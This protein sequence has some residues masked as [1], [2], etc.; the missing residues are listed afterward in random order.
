MKNSKRNNYVGSE[1]Y[2]VYTGTSLPAFI[3]L[4]AGITLPDPDYMIYR[5]NAD[6]FVFEYLLD[7]KG[8][9][10]QDEEEIEVRSGDAY[11]LQAGKNHY[12]YA[13]KEM[14]WTKIW[15]NVRGSLVRHLLSDYGLRQTVVIPQFGQGQYLQSMLSTIEE[16]PSECY[17]RLTIQLHEYIQALSS[18]YASHRK[19]HTF[20]FAMK[21]YIEQN[22]LRT[23]S[24]DDIAQSAHLSS[25]RAIHIFKEAFGLP[26]YQY[27][28]AQRL[29]LVQS[30]LLYTSLSIQEI[31]DRLGFS[32]YHHLSNSFKKAY[33][34]SPVKFRNDSR[35]YNSYGKIKA[36]KTD[37]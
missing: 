3:P 32:D 25:S 20:A 1:K 14:P 6:I 28:L 15:F 8:Y 12:Y 24:V 21:N 35:R 17:S 7:G 37:Q 33:G 22:L 13:D 26:P 10:C 29:E 34:V 23:L 36:S 30:M 11:I 16:D 4:M 5:S 18:Y 2:A 27:Y 19:E 31:S 9:I